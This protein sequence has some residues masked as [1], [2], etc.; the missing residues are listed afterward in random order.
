[1][2]QVYRL[3]YQPD[4]DRNWAVNPGLCTSMTGLVPLQSGNL[5][6]LLDVGSQSFNTTGEDV[7]HAQMF[8][9]TT[10][11]V[12]LLAFRTTNIDEYDSAGTRTNRATGLTTATRWEAAAWGNQIIAVSKANA[13]QSS[14]GAGFTALGGSSP[15]AACI[16]SNVNFVMMA[17]V[18]DGGSNVYTDMVWWSAI[19]NP[20]SWAASLATQAGNIRLLDTPGPILQLWAYGDKF[21]A[22]K[23]NSIYIGQYVGP[24]YVFSWRVVSNSIGCS[25]GKCVTECDGKVFFVH[26]SGFYMFDGQGLTN[27]GQGLT[28]KIVSYFPYGN[29]A[30]VADERQG[31]VY[32]F[33][34]QV[35]TGGGT[36][37]DLS[38]F[39]FN[40]RTGLWSA[41]G[42]V[43]T[44]T[45]GTASPQALVRATHTERD[46]FNALGLGSGF[47][48][49]SNGTTPKYVA[50]TYPGT[51]P[52]GTASFT[53]G[54]IGYNDIAQTEVKAYLRF[55]QGDGTSISSASVTGTND[56]L[57]SSGGSDGTHTLTWNTEMQTLDGR[58]QYRYK[59]ITVNFSAAN[60]Q[61]AGLG[62][63]Y[64]GSA[65]R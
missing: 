12:R 53:T 40:V 13:T 19:R 25:Y 26:K 31:I 52:T 36:F 61:I 59:T 55:L 32:F 11:A 41:L 64:A 15:K 1:M 5:S 39:C 18:D 42:L 45:S 14:T 2:P 21:L 37:Y 56:E 29:P 60:L 23:A 7:I 3:N 20:S 33:G 24:P 57:I 17:D 48:Y 44:Q 9:Q 10:G 22:F 4:L 50:T 38:G 46:A 63:D 51:L 16:A 34:S 47:S 35:T 58:A 6:T 54:Y 62:V 8:T 49:F 43:F 30:A 28:S 65:K 27:I